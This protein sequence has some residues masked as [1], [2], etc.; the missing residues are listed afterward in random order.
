MNR[1]CH[2]IQFA[3]KV[4]KKTYSNKKRQILYLFYIFYRKNLYI[5]IFFRTFV[6]GNY[7]PF[8]NYER[9][10]ISNPTVLVTD[11]VEEGTETE[12]SETEQEKEIIICSQN[13]Y[14]AKWCWQ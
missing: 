12:E 5:S 14:Y 8:S 4:Q 2:K 3:T 6:A 11:E 9:V 7:I 1:S 13:A 10:T